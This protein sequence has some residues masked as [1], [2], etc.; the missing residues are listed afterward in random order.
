[1]SKPVA[2]RALGAVMAFSMFAFNTPAHAQ[3]LPGR[4]EQDLRVPPEPVRRDSIRV[5]SPAFAD[6]VPAGAQSVRFTFDGVVLTGN[7]ALSTED[8]QPIWTP[9]VGQSVTLADVFAFAA[10]VSARY[11]EAGYVLSQAVVPAQDI[12]T[13]GPARV[14]IEVLEGY[15]DRVSFVGFSSP[16][17]AAHLDAVTAERPLKMST[18][19]RALL[20]VNELAGLSAQ[21]NL[22]AGRE[23]RS[24]ELVLVAQRM[25]ATFSA[26]LHNRTTPSQGR[27]RLELGGERRGLLGDFDRHALRWVG[28][29]DKRL[30]VLSYTGDA[31]VGASGLKAQWSAS[32]SSSDPASPLPNVDSDSK[33]LSLGAAYPVLR[34]RRSNIAV[35]ATLNGYDN[36]AGDGSLSR[37][38]IRALRLGL[39]ADHADELG[40][41]SLADVEVSK[42]LSGLGASRADDLRLNGAQPDFTKTTLYVAR[43]QSLGGDWSL[44]AA[45]TAQTADQ[46]LPSAEQL[47]LGGEV[48]L[49]GFDGS[50]VIGERGHAA[51]LELRRNAVLGSFSTTWYAFVDTGQVK[52]RQTNAAD[53]ATTL[54]SFGAGVRVSGPAGSKA[55]LEVAKPQRKNVTS[56]GDRDA[57][58]FAGVGVD[59]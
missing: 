43:L 53:L 17:L 39:T 38:R 14:R 25:P 31:P 10:A 2:Q 22:K 37:D 11:R 33:S 50:E 15:V 5:P 9:R 57:R 44:L 47:G 34:S 45:F 49:R 41:I 36:Q 58:A 42:G 13:D 30:N 16:L 18:L 35:R 28:S 3:A 20:L 51:K 40:G 29:G 55:Y 21:A 19:E 6:Q 52:R 46:R 48:F 7:K 59:F 54:A 1:M 23:P 32:V 8:L 12:G 56:Q 24:S 27:V 26:L 4:I